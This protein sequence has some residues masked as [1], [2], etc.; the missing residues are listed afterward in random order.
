MS[1]TTL[2]TVIAD[3]ITLNE[4]QKSSLLKILGHHCRFDTVGKLRRRIDSLSCQTQCL[5]YYGVMS[6]MKILPR[7]CEY[8]AGQSYTDEIRMIRKA[9]LD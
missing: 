5:N 3:G 7:R 1:Q 4:D 6:R 8:I 9:L 2:Y